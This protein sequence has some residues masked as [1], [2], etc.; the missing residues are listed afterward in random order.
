MKRF[1]LTLNL[2][3]DP[4][5]ISE[6]EAHH[7]NVWPEILESIKDAGIQDMQI[8][9]FG[10][11][12]FMVMDADDDFSFDKKNEN[13]KANPKVVQ[14]EQLMWNY[15]EPLK[16]ALH[17]EKWVVMNKIFDLKGSVK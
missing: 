10:T 17:G 8:Y 9:R 4:D 5:L 11:R 16:E 12:L 15:Q 1:C 14:W 13:D 7:K 3:N 2:K 6:Y